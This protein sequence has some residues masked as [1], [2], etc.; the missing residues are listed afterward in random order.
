MPIPEFDRKNRLQAR[1]AMAGERTA[2][3]LEQLRQTL[4]DELTVTIARRELRKWLR[5]SNEGRAV[6]AAVSRLL[7]G[8]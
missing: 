4:G 5:T 7:A 6:E 8:A 3:Q 2:K 1:T